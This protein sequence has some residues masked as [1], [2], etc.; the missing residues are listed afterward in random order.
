MNTNIRYTILLMFFFWVG[1]LH[2]QEH[3]AMF[4]LNNTPAALNLNPARVPNSEFY[5]DLPVFPK[6]QVSGDFGPIS[7][8]KL[9]KHDPDRGDSLVFDPTDFANSITKDEQIRG[10]VNADLLG[11]GF[12]VGS[13][14]ISLSVGLHA[15]ADVPYSK[16]LLL[17]AAKGNNA[18]LGKTMHLPSQGTQNEYYF[19]SINKCGIQHRYSSQSDRGCTG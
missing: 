8:Q 6:I 10:L 11:F 2:A 15:Y 17:F 5:I 18:F 3:P 16:D 9:F 7:F 4:F 12:H 14:F 13:S 19:I 1:G